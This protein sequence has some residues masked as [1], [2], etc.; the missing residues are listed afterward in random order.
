MVKIVY[1]DNNIQT[2]SSM[3]DKMC[4]SEIISMQR[5]KILQ[6]IHR[7][8]SQSY[9]QGKQFRSLFPSIT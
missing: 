3:V 5:D 6:I 7:F 8:L 9:K 4:F 2:Y 1:L